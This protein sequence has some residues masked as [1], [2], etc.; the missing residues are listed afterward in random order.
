MRDKIT[1]RDLEETQMQWQQWGSAGN[2]PGLQVVKCSLGRMEA[3]LT[4][5]HV[6]LPHYFLSLLLSIT[7]H[8]HPLGKMRKKET[9]EKPI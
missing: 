4:V 9:Q 5:H 7:F 8:F 1:H 3:A 2:S 6:G